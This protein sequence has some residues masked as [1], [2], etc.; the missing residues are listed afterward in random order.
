MRLTADLMPNRN[1][2]I[3][4]FHTCFALQNLPDLYSLK[5]SHAAFKSWGELTIVFVNNI[6]SDLFSVAL[7]NVLAIAGAIFILLA[8]IDSHFYF[9]SFV[10]RRFDD[11][12]Y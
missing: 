1:R 3:A 7:S 8:F 2:Y 4:N 5:L 10:H 11:E 9:T 12:A 6:K